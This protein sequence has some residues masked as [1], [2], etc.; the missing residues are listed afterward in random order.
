MFNKNLFKKLKKEHN[1]F[2][3]SRREV[4]RLANEALAKSK[5]AIFAFQRGDY[6]KGDNLFRETE[7]IFKYLDK[8]FRKNVAVRQE[9]ALK[10]AH[11]EFL[12]AKFFGKTS[13]GEKLDFVKNIEI[14]LE[15]YLGALCDLTGELVRSAINKAAAGQAK[16]VEKI[17]KII[18]DILGELI[19][20]DL[21]GYLRTKY[22]QAKH[23]LKKIEEIY[24]D[25]KIRK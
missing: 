14:S 18:E 25:I 9:G 10:A 17:K 5:Q 21:T 2:A 3:C 20:F 23:N 4:V 15:S 6:Q 19:Q 11:E 24:Y 12:E 7:N 16:E 22:D 1:D 13:R 8:K